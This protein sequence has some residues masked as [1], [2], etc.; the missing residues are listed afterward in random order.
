MV[1]SGILRIFMI[2]YNPVHQ[3]QIAPTID[4]SFF[5]RYIDPSLFPFLIGCFVVIIINHGNR[6]FL[7]SVFLN[8]RNFSEVIEAISKVFKIA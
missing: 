5:L 1:V 7:S 3:A 4:F 6:L 2:D 8:V